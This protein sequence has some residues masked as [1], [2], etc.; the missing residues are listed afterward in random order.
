MWPPRFPDLNPLDFLFWGCMRSVVN[1]IEVNSTEGF[2]GRIILSSEIVKRGALKGNAKPATLHRIHRGN[3]QYASFHC[4]RS[5]APSSASPATPRNPND[6]RWRIFI[7]NPSFIRQVDRHSPG[8]LCEI[9]RGIVL[10]FYLA[11]RNL[12]RS[13]VCCSAQLRQ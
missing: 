10:V 5:K 8:S 1:K 12:T 7:C 3:C 2:Q 4:I 13:K 6:G 11:H 9:H